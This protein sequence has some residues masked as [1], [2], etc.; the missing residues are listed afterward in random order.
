MKP[1][2]V[3][4]LPLFVCITNADATPL[5]LLTSGAVVTT[6]SDTTIDRRDNLTDSSNPDLTRDTTYLFSYTDPGLPG[7]LA[8]GQFDAFGTVSYGSIGLS[9]SLDMDGQLTRPRVT[10][11]SSGFWR[12]DLTFETGGVDG[13]VVLTFALDGNG[14]SDSL[15]SGVE[16]FHLLRFYG[17]VSPA[18]P[19]PFTDYDVTDSVFS[20]SYFSAPIPFVS[21][22]PVSVIGTAGTNVR[23][24]CVAVDCSAWSGSGTLDFGHTALLSGIAAFD[25]SG[26]PIPDFTIRSSSGTRYT[27]DGVAAVPEP[28]SMLLLGSG[29]VGLVSNARR[30]KRQQVQE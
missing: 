27:Q 13:T 20:T 5:L 11:F 24:T 10:T 26:A 29:L 2:V 21:G 23:F 8:E 12:D 14:T 25:L 28:A 22:V 30:R 1:L 9:M 3:V 16:G 19:D 7:G 6:S 18:S 15:S 4:L 17:G